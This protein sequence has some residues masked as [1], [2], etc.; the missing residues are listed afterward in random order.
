MHPLK[1]KICVVGAGESQYSRGTNKDELTLCLE[2][3]VQA[4]QEA[5]LKFQD[6]DSVIIPGLGSAT[7]GDYAANLGIRDLRYTVSLHEMGG[8][9]AVAS[10]EA[11]ALALAMG[12]ANYCL[13]PLGFRAYSG[14]RARE[15][16][17][18][19]ST[20]IPA[21]SAI[22]DFYLPFGMIAPPQFY[23]WMCLRHMQEFGTTHDQLGSV[24]VAM[25]KHAHLHANAVMK[26]RPMT[27]ED[28]HNSR[29]VSYPYHLLD[30]C[31]ETDGAAAVVL[32]TAERARDLQQR[33]VHIMGIASGH[34]Y[35][36]QELPNREDILTIGTTFAA[37]KA[38]QMAE[39]THK[40]MDFAQIYDCFTFQVVQQIEE[41]GF[42]Q[43]GEGGSFVQGGRIELG[44]ELP[45]NTHGGLLSQ[46]H[47]AGMNHVVEGV[48]Q[49]RH[50]CG[51]RQVEDA[52]IGVVT[53]WGGHGHGA[54]AI[55][56]R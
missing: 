13:V 47:V 45:V 25:R 11:A 27:L 7:A 49:L 54:V 39:V 56:R 10:M 12:V 4:I 22:R 44:G 16:S 32:T 17:A 52:E 15:M 18:E 51:E 53:G 21:A 50:Q 1:D 30:C 42:C 38:F 19:E 37:P 46:A 36:A 5:G 35:P 24:A 31:L 2:A 20:G 43:R 29:W 28:Y 9:M 40:D 41:A 34:P 8:A 55:L 23:S 6:I 14:R 3:S 26:G 48:R 33:P